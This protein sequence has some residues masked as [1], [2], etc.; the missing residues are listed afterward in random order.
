MNNERFLLRYVILVICQI[1]LSA[2]CS[3]SQY[4]VICILPVLVFSIPMRFNT[5]FAL[6]AAFV[7][8]LLADF[9]TTGIPGLTIVPLLFVAIL[10]RPLYQLV[11]GESSF[12]R[13]GG[14]NIARQGALRTFIVISV[15]LAVYLIVF[16]IV[17]GA[18]MRSFWFNALKFIISGVV[19]YF[20]CYVAINVL[21][22]ETRNRWR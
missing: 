14:L 9:F 2:L 13:Q 16:L 21:L 4:V 10:R 6:L 12:Q 7:T 15:P 19:S 17:D 20:A 1:L 22:S 8:G 18:G 11:F 3:L 5:H